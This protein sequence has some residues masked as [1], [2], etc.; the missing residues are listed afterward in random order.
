M[1]PAQKPR[2][3]PNETP[4][5]GPYRVRTC[6]CVFSMFCAES[7]FAFGVF[8]AGSRGQYV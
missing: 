4:V 2:N 8:C 5:A 6:F 3:A 7:C 1:T